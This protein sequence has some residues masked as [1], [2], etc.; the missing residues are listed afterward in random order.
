[1]AVSRESVSV[2]TWYDLS[3]LTMLRYPAPHDEDPVAE[4]VVDD[5]RRDYFNDAV[6]AYLRDIEHSWS[7]YDDGT[8]RGSF[9]P[10]DV[11]LDE[12]Q[13]TA[14]RI[15]DLQNYLNELIIYARLFA[16]EPATARTVAEVTGL[17]H[18]TIVRMATPELIAQVAARVQP[19]ARTQLQALQPATNPLFYR[20]L[21]TLAAPTTPNQSDPAPGS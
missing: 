11:V 12:L 2:E 18:S 3:V 14:A 4:E 19:V 6:E 7:E 10:P 20:R 5:Q 16:A 8:D 1:M 15:A 9:E 17:S 13:A 21:A